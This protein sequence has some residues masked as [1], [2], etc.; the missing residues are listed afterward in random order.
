MKFSQSLLRI[1]RKVTMKAQSGKP[2][3]RCNYDLS[4]I[5]PHNVN[6]MQTSCKRINGDQERGN[7][8]PRKDPEE[9]TKVTNPALSLPDGRSGLSQPTSASRKRPRYGLG[10]RAGHVRSNARS[11]AHIVASDNKVFQECMPPLSEPLRWRGT[12]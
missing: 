3:E 6:G 1:L 2:L 9:R 4:I 8:Q 10:L 7:S 5:V 11:H 12:G